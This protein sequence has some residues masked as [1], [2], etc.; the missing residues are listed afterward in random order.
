[1]N[2]ILYVSIKKYV[3]CLQCCLCPVDNSSHLGMI[4]KHRHERFC[5]GVGGGGQ[6]VPYIQV[7]EGVASTRAG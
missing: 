4:S 3:K 1:M 6:A 7:Y 2:N 5:E